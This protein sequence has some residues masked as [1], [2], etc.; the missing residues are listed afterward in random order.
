MRH[1]YDHWVEGLNGDWLISRQ[2]F[3][4]VPIPLWYPIGDDGEPNWDAPIVPD[5][6]TLPIDPSTDVPPGYTADQRGVDGGFIGDQDIM[7]TWATSSLTPADRRPVGRR[8]RAVRGA[9]SR[10]T[11]ARRAPR[12][13]ARGCSRP[14]CALTTSTV[15]CRGRRRRSTAGSWTRTAR[16]CRSRRATSSPR[17]RCSTATA[18]TPSATGPSRLDPG[19]DTAFSEDQ[20]KVGRRLATKLLNVTKFVLG[21]GDTRG[22]R[23]P[24]CH[25]SDRP[26]DAGAAGRRDRRRH[27][28]VRGL[29]LRP[30]AGAHRRVLLVVLRRLRRTG[31]GPRLRR[32]RRRSGGV[33]ARRARPCPRRDDTGCWRPRC[34]SRPRKRGAGG[35]TTPYTPRPGPPHPDRRRP[36]TRTS[37]STPSARCWVGCGAP[38]PR[39]RLSQRAAVERL[40]LTTPGETAT[41]CHRGRSRRPGRCP[42]HPRA[43]AHHG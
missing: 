40:A 25:R 7:D 18:P 22:L 2:R 6:T 5:E 28:S 3:F 15:R 16:R 37:I 34:R 27:A 4:G 19:V 14:S 12:S 21:M 20:M 43:H 13:S 23:P 1:R 11:S 10:W 38:R 33:G 31:Q 41:R 35:T 39:P 17:W 24:G 32:P 26:G 36:T 8:P 42:H 30:G 29:R 9:C